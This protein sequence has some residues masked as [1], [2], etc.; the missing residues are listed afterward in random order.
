MHYL[1]LK[2]WKF[3]V[4]KVLW[5]ALDINKNICFHFRIGIIGKSIEFILGDKLPW[6]CEAVI[7][8][9]GYSPGGSPKEGRVSK[10]RKKAVNVYVTS[11]MKTRVKVFGLVNVAFRITVAKKIWAGLE[12]HFNSVLCKGRFAL[13]KR[14]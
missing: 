14:E 7:A 8:I 3:L 6:V 10:V 13:S 1:I 2:V 11:L 4:I 12:S 9:Y 5:A